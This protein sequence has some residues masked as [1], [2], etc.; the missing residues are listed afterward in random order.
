MKIERGNYIFPAGFLWG[1]ATASHQ[2]EGNNVNDW[3]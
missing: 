1:A 3:S 2:V